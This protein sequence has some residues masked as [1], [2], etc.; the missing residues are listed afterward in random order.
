MGLPHQ[1]LDAVG[2]S[3]FIRQPVYI[4]W[5]V[6][7]TITLYYFTSPDQQLRLIILFNNGHQDTNYTSFEDMTQQWQD[8]LLFIGVDTE[9]LMQV[10]MEATQMNY[11]L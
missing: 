8:D 6:S 1:K 10:T 9:Q 11:T 3:G 5:Q 7:C 2:R 4:Y